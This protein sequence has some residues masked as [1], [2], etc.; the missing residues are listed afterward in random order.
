MFITLSLLLAAAC[1][2]PAAGK[3][4]GHSKMLES[5]A[6][7]GLSWPRDRLIGFAELAA[8]VGVLA[9]FALHAL[10]VAAASS[11]TVLVL[12]ALAVH[13]RAGD[14]PREAVPAVLTLGV[15]LAYL[16]V[17]LVD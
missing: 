4:L 2:V 3:L 10:G 11:M 8:A 17:A 7:F 14:R 15:S 16:V 12:G 9:G 1:L 5:A 6:R 13:R